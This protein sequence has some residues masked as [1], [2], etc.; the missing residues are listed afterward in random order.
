MAKSQ[1]DVRNPQS[2]ID[3]WFAVL[4]QIDLWFARLTG[5]IWVLLCISLGSFPCILMCSVLVF[6]VYLLVS[7]L[8][9]SE[10]T[11]MLPR[12]FRSIYSIQENYVTDLGN[13]CPSLSRLCRESVLRTYCT[14]FPSC[15]S[16]RV[17]CCPIVASTNGVCTLRSTANGAAF[18]VGYSRACLA[19]YRDCRVGSRPI[20]IWPRQ[21]EARAVPKA[22]SATLRKNGPVGLATSIGTARQT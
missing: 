19:R 9:P 3:L 21:E 10:C 14:R 13:Y 12:S 2:Q 7:S 18:Y 16:R 11:R 1:H 4:S 22:V 8:E 15:R 20:S 6:R 17:R 5:L